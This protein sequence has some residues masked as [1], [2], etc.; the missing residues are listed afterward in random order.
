MVWILVGAVLMLLMIAC[1]N[2]ANLLL[3]R[4]TARETELAVRA[5]LGASQWRLM[6][7]LLAESFVLAAAGTAAGALMAY[8]G[9]QWVRA[10]IPANALP[11]EMSIRFSGQALVAT[12]GVAVLTALVS[13]L[14]P[15]LRAGRGNLQRRLAG[16]GKGVGLRAGH[17]RLRTLLVSVQVTLAIVLLVGAGLMMRSLIELQDVDLGLNPKNVLTGRF[18]FPVN[19]RLT[20]LERSQFIQRV[21]EKVS[22]LPGVIAVSPSAGMPVQGGPSL[23]VAIPGTTLPARATAVV[24]SI[25]DGYFRTLGWPVVSGRLLSD[26]DVTSG[27]RVAVVNR[28]FGEQFLDGA[29]PIGRTLTLGR[30]DP[31]NPLLFEIVGVVGDAHNSGWEGPIRPQVFVP[32]T[33]GG[34]VSPSGILIRTGVE[35]MTLQ[36]TVRQQIWAVDQGVA[37]MNPDALETVLHRGYLAAPTFGLGLMSVFAAV[38]LILAA[39]GVFSVM[40]YTVSLQTHE[41]AIRMA[42]GA[43][44]NGVL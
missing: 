40:A 32:Y 38:G 22:T 12:V 7:Q 26:S 30:I 27:R 16:S 42:L 17:G 9:L 23:P 3:A 43:E 21:L 5:S 39:I 1:S 24:E 18:A 19:Q 11:A 8:A 10:A 2:V 37:L 31:A 34:P 44:P 14:A 20:A 28:K 29:D 36:H 13:G 35:P 33:A 6:R 25:S 4:A 41:I 15:A